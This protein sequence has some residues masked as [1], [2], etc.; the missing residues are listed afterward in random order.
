MKAFL[1]HSIL[2]IITEPLL[3]LLSKFLL[4]YFLIEETLPNLPVCMNSSM[5][6]PRS[7]WSFVPVLY[8][9]G[10]GL[11][12]IYFGVWWLLKEIILVIF[13]SLVYSPINSK[14]SPY[15]WTIFS[16][17]SLCRFSLIFFS[18]L[19]IASFLWESSYV[20]L[21]NLISIFILCSSLLA[22]YKDFI[23]ICSAVSFSP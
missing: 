22:S 13:S 10:C 2:S 15:I 23:S 21:N 20:N 3:L 6:L 17:Q 19:L 12:G 16:I 4:V 8:E 14:N 9:A 7:W 18:K 11:L 5:F 1:I